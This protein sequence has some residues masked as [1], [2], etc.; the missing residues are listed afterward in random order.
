MDYDYRESRALTRTVEFPED[1]ALGDLYINRLDAPFTANWPSLGHARGKVTVPADSLL[2]LYL[3]PAYVMERIE[4]G[5]HDVVDDWNA[6]EA[7]L[8]LAPLA[9]LRPDDLQALTFPNTPIDDGALEP[10]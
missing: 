5:I 10:L 1:R 4:R 8:D 6:S 3:I 2:S 7:T 9:R